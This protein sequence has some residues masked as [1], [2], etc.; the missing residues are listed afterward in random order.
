VD[1]YFQKGEIPPDHVQ[2]H[3]LTQHYGIADIDLGKVKFDEFKKNPSAKLL[4]DA[5]HPADPGHKLYAD[6]IMSFL[7]ERLVKG[8]SVKDMPVPFKENPAEPNI[9]EGQKAA[10]LGTGWKVDA[11]PLGFMRSTLTVAD[12]AK[13]AEM[14]IPFT[15]SVMGIYWLQTF[16]GGQLEWSVDGQPPQRLISSAEILVKR[17]T[18]A[19]N[20]DRLKATLPYGEHKLTI[21][22]S[23]E[24]PPGSLGTVIKIGA[25][26]TQ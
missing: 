6:A 19:L 24:K 21:R 18:M 16:D 1:R 10:A 9:L 15:G 23:S 13:G 12:P 14:I 7:S 20:F 26:V 25:I 3:A 2:L 8:A 11:R 5:V 22:A 17:H 4:S